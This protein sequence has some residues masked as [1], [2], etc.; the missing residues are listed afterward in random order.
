MHLGPNRLDPTASILA[1]RLRAGHTVRVRLWGRSMLP[2]VRPGARL[3]F[4]PCRVEDVGVGDL[5]LME[6]PVGVIA[7]RAVDVAADRL[8][9][10]GDGLTEPDP[11]WPA[12]ALLGRACGLALGR[13]Q[14][15]L[16]RAAARPLDR[17]LGA[18]GRRLAA[19]RTGLARSAWRT[20]G[21][22]LVD[23]SRPLRLRLQ[24]F[25]LVPLREEW[26]ERLGQLE[27]RAGRRPRPETLAAWRGA[28]GGTGAAWLAVRGRTPVGWLLAEE[29]ED[30]ARALRLWVESGSRRL[31]IGSGLVERMALTA[32][33]RGW[34]R[35]RVHAPSSSV[36]WRRRGFLPGGA[37]SEILERA[38]PR[39]GRCE[40]GA[41]ER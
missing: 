5:V 31:G 9:T 6:G 21:L 35:L 2:A 37:G 23:A 36:F 4:E 26:R 1:D 13:G 39:P 17:A 18:A 25:E 38:V 33:E 40:P 11:P 16:P 7:H 30:G 19:A 22:A 34:E 24:P 29:V 41:L 10:W 8:L 20:P 12:G 28:L 15:P 14:L 27:L 32:S 3:T